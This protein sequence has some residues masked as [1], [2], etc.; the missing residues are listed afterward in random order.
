M[1][2]NRAEYEKMHLHETK[3][4]WYKILHKKVL[5]QIEANFGQNKSIKI[6]DAGCGTGG[7][8][9]FLK[10]NGYENLNGFDISTDAVDFCNK[11]G[12]KVN[13][14]DIRAIE[15]FGPNEKFEVI[16]CND[17]L[18]FLSDEEIVKT[19]QIFSQKLNNQGLIL[20]NIHAF[21]VF[22]GTHD[23]AVGSNR[24]FVLRQF[25]HF[26]DRAGVKIASASYWSLLLSPLI[27]AARLWQNF[28]LKIG[29]L[30]YQTVESD[31][32]YPG[33]FI[34]NLLYKIVKLEEK[35]IQKS[36]FGSSLNMTLQKIP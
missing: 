12:L 5:K 15:N 14:L 11:K 6:L 29:F 2:G 13:Q 34:N 20:L 24:R 35:F 8:L 18:Y 7:L 17:M 31:V 33:N 10:T 19:L 16:I 25:Q 23:I 27:L 9:A 21:E 32:S 22:S 28:K 3:L 1:I 30:N 36:P 4:W 26:A